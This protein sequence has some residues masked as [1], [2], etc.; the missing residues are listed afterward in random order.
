M[1]LIHSLP[2]VLQMMYNLLLFHSW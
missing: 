2:K 1:M